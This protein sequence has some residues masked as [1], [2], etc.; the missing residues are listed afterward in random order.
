MDPTQEAAV[1]AWLMAKYAAAPSAEKAS[2]LAYL[3][4]TAMTANPPL[5]AAKVVNDVVSSL[6]VE[7]F[8]A[9]YQISQLEP[10]PAS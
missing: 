10:L 3:V 9:L 6:P 4:G 1:N 2:F 5:D 7:I 8:G